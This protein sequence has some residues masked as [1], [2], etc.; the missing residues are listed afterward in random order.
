M[1][2]APWTLRQ[3]KHCCHRAWK[4]HPTPSWRGN[5]HLHRTISHRPQWF[6]CSESKQVEMPQSIW[7]LL[8]CPCIAGT[9]R[10]PAW[11]PQFH[12]FGSPRHA[13]NF[14]FW[15][16]CISAGRS[17]NSCSTSCLT[18]FHVHPI[19]TIC[20]K[21]CSSNGTLLP[22]TRA[23]RESCP[24]GHS[25]SKPGSSVV[26]LCA[27]LLTNETVWLPDTDKHLSVKR[28]LA[29]LPP[30]CSC[31]SWLAWNCWDL[32]AAVAATSKQMP[33]NLLRSAPV[34]S[35]LQP[36]ACTSAGKHIFP[37]RFCGWIKNVIAVQLG[38]IEQAMSFSIDM[39]LFTFTFNSNWSS[40][41]AASTKFATLG[42]MLPCWNSENFDAQ[43][44]DT[45]PA[46]VEWKKWNIMFVLWGFLGCKS[47]S[48]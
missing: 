22:L 37:A 14:E 11:Q 44:H 40:F 15:A 17:L 6:P 9:K 38:F 30:L 16:C 32:V 1:S 8:P 23:S 33:S 10:T 42:S 31:K 4:C 46:L 27:T 36:L 41:F 12:S 43:S 39:I 24:F 21:G 45:A 47:L 7:L 34:F 20:V 26:H 2:H 29:S 35:S 3:C 5:L 25:S 28:T 13:K 19:F 48:T 18:T